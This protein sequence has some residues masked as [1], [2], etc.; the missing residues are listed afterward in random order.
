[1]WG[2]SHNIFYFEAVRDKFPAILIIMYNADAARAEAGKL[3]KEA[4]KQTMARLKISQEF[5]K[6]GAAKR[7]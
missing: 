4:E 2:L 6:Q 5:A 1:M 7:L 3:E